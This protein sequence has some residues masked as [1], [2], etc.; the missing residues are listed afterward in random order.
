MSTK[1]RSATSKAV[2]WYGVKTLYRWTAAHPNRLPNDRRLRAA[3][4]I[5]ER[6]V[7]VKAK[8]H[9]QAISLAQ[10]EARRYQRGAFTNPYGQSVQVK[11]LGCW[12]SYEL[13]EPPAH[14]HEAYSLTELIDTRTPVRS[15][16]VA[17][18][19]KSAGP[20]EQAIRNKFADHQFVR[21][22]PP[23]NDRH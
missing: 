19:G 14:L 10:S 12:D 5:E 16:V 18:M 8:G 22:K 15:I 7:L 2:R 9:R 21:V 23:V 4:L 6:V 17:K 11:N 3:A 20:R 1:K 13:F